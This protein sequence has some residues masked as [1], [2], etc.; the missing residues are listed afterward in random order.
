M[1]SIKIIWDDAED[2]VSHDAVIQIGDNE[3][4]QAA[5]RKWFREYIEECPGLKAAG[6]STIDI[7]AIIELDSGKQYVVPCLLD[8]K[9]SS[10]PDE[11][12]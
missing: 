10:P 7:E 8:E 5:G 11:S 6:A 1:R 4:A 12:V 2:G 3:D 9:P